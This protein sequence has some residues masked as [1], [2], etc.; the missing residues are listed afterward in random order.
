MLYS[1]T[2]KQSFTNFGFKDQQLSSHLPHTHSSSGMIQHL[3]EKDLDCFTSYRGKKA[4]RNLL[5]VE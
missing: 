1:K 4:R 5:H 3:R 2:K